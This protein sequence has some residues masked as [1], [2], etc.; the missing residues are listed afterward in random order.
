MEAMRTRKQLALDTNLLLDLAA[1]G[2]FAHEFKE[3]FQSRGYGL[4][5]PPTVLAE[6]HEQSVNSPVT[7]KRWLARMALARILVWDVVPL[8]LSAVEAGIAERLANR[9]LE[10]RLLPAFECN[11]ALILAETALA[12]VPLLVTSD[13]HLLDID[14]GCAGVGLQRR[15]SACGARCSSKGSG[16]GD[17]RSGV[18]TQK[19]A[20]CPSPRITWRRRRGKCG[21]ICWRGPNAEVS[22]NWRRAPSASLSLSRACCR[23]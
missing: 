13:R 21:R 18:I 4:L 11:D 9:F 16:Q 15:R 8:H 12:K 2:D 3:V 20:K 14:E 1:A 7:R 17:A 5:A 6:L 10:L 19:S 22:A 23:G